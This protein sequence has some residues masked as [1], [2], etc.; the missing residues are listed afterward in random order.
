MESF[1]ATQGGM[2]GVLSHHYNPKGIFLTMSGALDSST[3]RREDVLTAT[4]AR[5]PS[6]R[7][8]VTVCIANL[9]MA[10]L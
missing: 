2:H 3:R 1:Y 5:T 8:K 6:A 4:A 10:A 7:G 9:K